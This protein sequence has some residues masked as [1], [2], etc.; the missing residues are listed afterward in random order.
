MNPIYIYP[1]IF[2]EKLLE[3]YRNT[4]YRYFFLN[5][6]IYRLYM[7]RKEGK[8]GYCHA[9][10]IRA[11]R[12]IEPRGLWIPACA[13]MTRKVF[14]RTGFLWRARDVIAG[15]FKKFKAVWI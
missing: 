1:R 2:P 6:V 10:F 9:R 11:S 5:E 8:E 13:G 3:K 14:E 4:Y 12:K 15:L 7:L